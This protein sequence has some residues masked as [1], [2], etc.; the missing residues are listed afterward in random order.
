[1][2]EELSNAF[3]PL[4]QDSLKRSLPIIEAEFRLSVKRHR[5][6]IEALGDCWNDEVVSQRL[7]P[8][9]R[10]EIVPIVRKHGQPTAE[11]IGREALGPRVDLV[12]RLACR[13]RWIASCSTKR[14]GARRVGPLS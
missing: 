9:A 11:E 12:F 4:V 7:V 5:S 10:R 14:S 1:M 8:L 6:E 2:G 3:V 13:L